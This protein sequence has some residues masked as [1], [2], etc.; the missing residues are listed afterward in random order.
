VVQFADLTTAVALPPA[1]EEA[2]IKGLAINIAPQ[3]PA[4]ILQPGTV[5]AYKAAMKYINRINN[6][7][8]TMT[9][10]NNILT[11]RGGSLAGF[12]GGY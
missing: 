2:L 5:A 9:L 7:V 3:Y 8:P 10:D 11:K 1:Y 4:G 6:V 12:L